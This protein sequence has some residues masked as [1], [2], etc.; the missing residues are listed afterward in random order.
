MAN[1]RLKS[2][3]SDRFYFLGLQNH[4]RWWLQSW[5][6]K[7]VASWKVSYDKPTQGIK[8]QRHYFAN[9][10]PCSQ[11]YGFSSSCV[12]MWELDCKDGWAPKNWCSGIMVLEKTLET[13]LDGKEIKPVNPKGN[14]HWIF[15]GRTDVEVEVPIQWL[16]DAESWLTGKNSDAGKERRQRRR[17]KP[18]MWWWESI[19]DSKDMNLS[20]LLERVEDRRAWHAVVHGVKYDLVTDQQ[21]EQ[22]EDVLHNVRE[23]SQY[24]D[25][26]SWNVNFMLFVSS[27]Q[28]SCS[29]MSD[30][31]WL[32][33]L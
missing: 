10:G 2:G 9:K 19:T 27:A 18:R 16:L 8:K 1:R 14:Q 15:I 25:Y 30:S 26:N 11:I 3:S 20:K 13:L 28:F 21:Q 33:G 23:Y 31:L 32:Y 24:L 17:R 7:M 5:N 6:W 22:P 12:W 4:C 29:V